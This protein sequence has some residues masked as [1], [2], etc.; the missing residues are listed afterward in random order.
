MREAKGPTRLVKGSSFMSEALNFAR[1]KS[2]SS[3][4]NRQSVGERM[5]AHFS[6]PPELR[7]G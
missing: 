4:L 6:E 5:G 1:T 3:C 2:T 7:S